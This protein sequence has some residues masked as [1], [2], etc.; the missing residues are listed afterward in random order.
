MR[1]QNSSGN[2]TP[3]PIPRPQREA[4]FTWALVG[5]GAI[6]LLFV[7]GIW[8]AFSKDFGLRKVMDNAVSAS[9]NGERILPLRQA[10]TQYRSSHKGAYPATVQA[11]VPKYLPE[12]TLKELKEKGLEYNAPKQDASANFVVASVAGGKGEILGQVQTTYTRLLKDDSI[13]M[14]QVTRTVLFRTG[15]SRPANPFSQDD[16]ED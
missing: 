16:K 6:L 5:C 3:P 10:I 14:D 1:R 7:A 15:A 13:V 11:L 2:S 12:E 4:G 9:T 8:L